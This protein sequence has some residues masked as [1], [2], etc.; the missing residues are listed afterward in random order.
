MIW[1]SCKSHG[2]DLGYLPVLNPGACRGKTWLI[3]YVGDVPIRLVVEAN[4]ASDA[5]DVLSNDPEFGQDL[6][7]VNVQDDGFS[8]ERSGGA[9]PTQ[10]VRIHGC[11]DCDQPYPVRYHFDGLPPQGIDPRRY[12]VARFN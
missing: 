8:E 10:M 3:D 5:I 7:F 4:S 9:F 11:A 6:Q 1:A 2:V 12:A